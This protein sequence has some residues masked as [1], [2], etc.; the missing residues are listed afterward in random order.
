MASRTKK[1]T[2]NFGNSSPGFSGDRTKRDGRR[3]K[4]KGDGVDR[5][6]CV[7][8]RGGDEKRSGQT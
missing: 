6:K 7:G 5:R 4:E 2:L 8:D 1:T 3:K